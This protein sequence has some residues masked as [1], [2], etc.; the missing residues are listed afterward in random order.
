MT[1]APWAVLPC[2]FCKAPLAPF[3]FAPRPGLG[4]SV[5]RPITTC[6]DPECQA[7]ARARVAALEAA[8]DPLA[9]VRAARK[10]DPAPKSD[11][12]QKSLF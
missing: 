5:R 8:R 3:G 9:R 2:D 10:A 11:P 6:N 12:A 7:Q 1:G 4:L